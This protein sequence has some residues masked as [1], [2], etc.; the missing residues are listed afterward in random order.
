MF[1]VSLITSLLFLSAL[2]FSQQTWYKCQGDN[3]CGLDILPQAICNNGSGRLAVAARL[4]G[5]ASNPYSGTFAAEYIDQ[6]GKILWIKEQSLQNYISVTTDVA[7][8]QN[9]NIAFEYMGGLGFLDLSWAVF[10]T[11]GN[12]LY[13]RNVSG[14]NFVS[15]RLISTK[16]SVFL[17]GYEWSSLN[18]QE[19]VLAKYLPD[20]TFQWV[21]CFGEAGKNVVFNGGFEMGDSLCVYGSVCLPGFPGQYYGL[22]AIFDVNGNLLQEHYYQYW[23]SFEEVHPL[24]GGGF[25]VAVQSSENTNS[26]Q[27]FVLFLN[28]DFTPSHIYGF[29]HNEKLVSYNLDVSPNGKTYVTGY[30]HLTNGDENSFILA[31]SENQRFLWSRSN[32]YVLEGDYGKDISTPDNCWAW[33]AGWRSTVQTIQRMDPDANAGNIDTTTV[34]FIVDS[35]YMLNHMVDSVLTEIP[36]T[37]NDTIVPLVLDTFAIMDSI[38]EWTATYNYSG[39]FGI[40]IQP[41]VEVSE[42]VEVYPNPFSAFLVVTSYKPGLEYQLI[43]SLGQTVNSGILYTAKQT[44]NTGLLPSGIYF[45]RVCSDNDYL[46]TFTLINQK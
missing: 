30:Y 8:L 20:G 2:S 5:C 12:Y 18:L 28:Q 7:M 4:T 36:Y 19:G 25:V 13:S 34:P 40:G 23:A 46:K 33:G 10:D 29:S 6:D 3:N 35:S 45:L 22:I 16:S 9:G 31:F 44:I 27:T 26:T 11:N 24:P 39:C 42:P 1:R 15:K 32:N 37:L 14:R 38:C 17:T 43:N 21:K 41:D